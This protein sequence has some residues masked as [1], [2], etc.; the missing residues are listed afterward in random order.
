MHP[1][2]SD[3]VVTLTTRAVHWYRLHDRSGGSADDLRM[4]WS[5]NNHAG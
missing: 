5:G 2:V 3:L 1:Y 4:T